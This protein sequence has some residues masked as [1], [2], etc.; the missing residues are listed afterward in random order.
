M[1]HFCLWLLFIFLFALHYDGG[2]ASGYFL[3]SVSVDTLKTQ[4]RYAGKVYRKT[5]RF[6]KQVERNYEKYKKRL[7][8]SEKKLQ[9]E[10]CK[11]DE[12]LADY[13]YSYSF[14][15]N[16]PYYKP[17][18]ISVN[19]SHTEQTYFSYFNTLKNNIEKIKKSVQTGSFK[20]SKLRLNRKISRAETE[21]SALE[22]NLL[23]TDAMNNYMRSRKVI[24]G[25]ALKKYPELDNPL[26]DYKKEAFYYKATFNEY[27]NIFKEKGALEN[28]AANLFRQLPVKKDALPPVP[29]LNNVTG[30]A[31]SQVTTP[32][33]VTELTGASPN[34]QT[35][36]EVQA[37]MDKSIADLGNNAK[38]IIEKN[39]LDM[40][41]QLTK[42][43]KEFPWIENIGDVPDFKVNP[44]KSK[45]FSE[46]IKYGINFQFTPG[47][48]FVPVAGEIGG[49]VGYMFTQKL[50]SGVS[51]FYRAG[52]GD[53]LRKFE[54][55]DNGWSY[56][57]Y[58]EYQLRR[59][60]YVYGTF[61]KKY[62]T[63]VNYR[64]ESLNKSA[65]KSSA[66]LGAKL[67]VETK[68]KKRA[69]SMTLLYD[70]LH[71]NKLPFTPALVYRAG[72]EF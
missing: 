70:F 14:Y 47:T 36:A 20:K 30:N 38:G 52:F 41:S 46:R 71:E 24:L 27:K 21:L 17:G 37:M 6:N 22:E 57:A 59:I 67:K 13:L 12:R 4:T 1:K 39:M 58:S 55:S 16:A 19:K 32:V 8:R 31:L 51:T 72:W 60:L 42:A 64:N 9:K 5:K 15:K 26:L 28:E 7:A 53:G 66:M 50:T 44:M 10:L 18:L 69:Y 33:P 68:K 48:I 2:Y 35:N 25:S 49:S 62:F 61:E 65:W 23:Q 56:G 40:H 34:L 3:S 45:P 11:K 29:E 43:K 63:D 54:W